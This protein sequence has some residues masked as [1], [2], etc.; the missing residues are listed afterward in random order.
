MT[1]FTEFYGV[2]CF[3]LLSIGVFCSSRAFDLEKHLIFRLYTLKLR[4]EFH[5][6][7]AFNAPFI[8]ATLFDPKR[9]TRIFVHGFLSSEHVLI[10]YKEAFLKLG[11]YNFIGV[12]WIH[13]ARTFNYFLA[14][15]RVQAVCSIQD[16]SSKHQRISRLIFRILF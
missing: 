10:R 13:G 16:F 14:K 11:D 3:L 2:K 12:D 6:L 8:S 7:N 9:P 4:D 1:Y 5:A 15:S